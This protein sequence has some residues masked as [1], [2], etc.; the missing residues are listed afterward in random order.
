[1]QSATHSIAGH[2][3]YLNLTQLIENYVVM[4]AAS[5]PTLRPLLHRKRATR[6]T[7]ASAS[8]S[9]KFRRTFFSSHG[10]NLSGRSERYGR[11]SNAS[12]QS[13]LEL[14]TV[15]DG[16]IK[17]TTAYEVAW[18]PRTSADALGFEGVAPGPSTLNLANCQA[19]CSSAAGVL[20]G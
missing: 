4:I 10:S 5:I 12:G 20:P 7:Y 6:R 11:N 18:E 19:A 8:K 17:K 14:C 16:Q 2:I 9:S 15:T 1:M 3:N 13:D